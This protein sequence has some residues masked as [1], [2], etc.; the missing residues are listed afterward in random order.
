ML[1]A[2]AARFDVTEILKIFWISGWTKQGPVWL[3]STL[4]E[5]QIVVARAVEHPNFKFG[6]LL[7]G[8]RQLVCRDK[9]STRRHTV[10]E[11]QRRQIGPVIPA[12]FCE[13][14]SCRRSS[15]R[16][17]FPVLASTSTPGCVVWGGVDKSSV[18]VRADCW[19]T[20]RRGRM[21]VHERH[22]YL[23]VCVCRL[24]EPRSCLDAKSFGILTLYYFRFYLTNIV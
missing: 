12:C 3:R 2:Y 5:I 23:S 22:A 9:K 7:C 10:V 1:H 18:W 20:G 21:Q 19:L 15:R 13:A 24:V 4:F 11:V 14:R 16:Q 17:A 6:E 8:A